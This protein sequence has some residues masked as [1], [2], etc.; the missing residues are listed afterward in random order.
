MVGTMTWPLVVRT[1]RILCNLAIRVNTGR[2]APEAGFNL[3]HQIIGRHVEKPGPL[4]PNTQHH[5]S[6]SILFIF[7]I[8]EVTQVQGGC[9][10]CRRQEEEEIQEGS[11]NL[12]D[13]SLQGFEAGSP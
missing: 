4:F 6:S 7:D 13:L 5:P 3:N 10:C 2:I 8:E 11:R 12:Q 1:F 9:W